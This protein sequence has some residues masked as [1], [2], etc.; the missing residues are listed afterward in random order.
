MA[1]LTISVNDEAL[2]RARIRALEENRVAET[3]LSDA[4][5]QTCLG[6]QVLQ[7][8]YVAVTRKLGCSMPPEQA[9]I[10]VEQFQLFPASVVSNTLVTAAIRRGIDS[11]ISFWDA[12]IV[13]TAL[14][15]RADRHVTE[16]LQDGW[17]IGSMPVWSPFKSLTEDA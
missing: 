14:A 5:A 11:R 13:E 6:T 17:Q 12:L 4:L 3:I 15:A 8:L 10:A 2:K 9:L 16:D 7:E 1:N